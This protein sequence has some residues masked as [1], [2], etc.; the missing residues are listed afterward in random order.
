[1][2]EHAPADKMTAS[3]ACGIDRFCRFVIRVQKGEHGGTAP[4]PPHLVMG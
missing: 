1:M 2:E 3:A 4:I